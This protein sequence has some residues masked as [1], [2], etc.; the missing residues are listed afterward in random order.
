MNFT[1]G[2][3][4]KKCNADENCA[5][6]TKTAVVPHNLV[7]YNYCYSNINQV[8]GRDAI[9]FPLKRKA[10]DNLFTHSINKINQNRITFTHI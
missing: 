10:D 7:N 1:F 8:I 2:V 9:R 5:N 6:T 3:P 4:I